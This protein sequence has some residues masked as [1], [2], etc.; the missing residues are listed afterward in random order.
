MEI[1]G[2]KDFPQ[3][4]KEIL[5]DWEKNRIFEK[6][7]EKN[8][9]N[10]RFI[11]LEGPPTANGMPHIGHA[12]TR[13]VKDIILRYKAMNGFDVQ[14]WIGGWDCHGL[15]VEIEVE[16]KLGINSKKEIEKFGVKEFNKLCRESVFTYRDEWIKMTKRIGFWIDMDKA[17]VTMEDYY[18]ESVWWA[19][20][21]IY[22]KE[23]QKS[24]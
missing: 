13:A 24:V 4:E 10:R 17:Y 6:L 9:G 12:L 18:I 11:F 1:K 23:I 7:R 8:R 14:P 2:I 15:P 3:I 5:E 21:E 22:E 19:L 16:K 20:K